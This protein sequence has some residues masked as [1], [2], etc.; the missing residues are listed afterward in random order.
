MNETPNPRLQPRA[1]RGG[2]PSPQNDGDVAMPPVARRASRLLVIDPDGHV[3]L[4]QYED[5]R[6]RYWATPGGG[7]EGTET[8]EDA[9]ARE[10]AEEL[11][12]TGVVADSLWENTVEFESKGTLIRQTER[13]FVIRR[14]RREVTIGDSVREAHARE[15]IVATRWWSPSEITATTERVFPENLGR[16]LAGGAATPRPREPGDR[17]VASTETE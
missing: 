9:V 10:A 6:G 8:F 11:G 7:L 16:R 15:G 4:V 14:D 3:L 1:R 12:L 17:A 5:A 13:Y 2:A